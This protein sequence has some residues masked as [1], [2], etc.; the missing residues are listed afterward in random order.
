V[1]PPIREVERGM[2]GRTLE[3]VADHRSIG[4]ATRDLPLGA[5]RRGQGG[6]R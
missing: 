1:R 5:A 3:S 4:P 2:A 6:S